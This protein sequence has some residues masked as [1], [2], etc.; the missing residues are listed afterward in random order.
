[1]IKLD[2]II[3]ISDPILEDLLELYIESF[4][5]RERRE[6][7]ALKRHI[8][9]KENMFFNAIYESE[10]LAG[11]IIY[12]NFDEFIY[13]EHL[14]IFPEMRN[15]KIGRQILEF[16]AANFS[17][18]R[19]LEVE[20]HTDELSGRRIDFYQRSGYEVLEKNYIQPPYPEH[21]DE[22]ISLWIMGNTDTA[23]KERLPEYIRII[24]EEV[25]AYIVH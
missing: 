5:L 19:L 17:K 6:T 25:Y 7:D 18:T 4:P 23:S 16:L 14:A 2:R 21:E 9:N 8:T 3:S 15:R 13:V 11:F 20:P 12:W 24:K 10:E 22:G 1:M